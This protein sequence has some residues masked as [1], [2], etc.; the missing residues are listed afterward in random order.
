MD[1]FTVSHLVQGW[2]DVRLLLATTDPDEVW[3]VVSSWP[4]QRLAVALVAAVMVVPPD[5]A[6]A[7]DQWTAGADIAATG[8]RS[9]VS[10]AGQMVGHVA[11]VERQR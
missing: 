8:Q 5:E 6:T 7:A 2:D 9:P 3:E 11:A 4:T 1:E 10:D